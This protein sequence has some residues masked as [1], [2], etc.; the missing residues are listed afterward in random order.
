MY[1]FL[2]LHVGYFLIVLYC[3]NLTGKSVLCGNKNMLFSHELCRVYKIKKQLVDFN[4]I[5]TR[6][7]VQIV[8]PIILITSLCKYGKLSAQ[9]E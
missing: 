9:I 7:R 6:S 5:F 2:Y 1:I 4:N 3:V 8:F